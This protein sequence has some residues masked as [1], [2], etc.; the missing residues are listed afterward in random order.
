MPA[1]QT[2]QREESEKGVVL[3]GQGRQ[4]ADPGVEI[5]VGG[6]GRQRSGPWEERKGLNVPEGQGRQVLLDVYVPGG[7]ERA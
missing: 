5:S 1:G 7:Q 4:R 2:T 6:Q 3:G